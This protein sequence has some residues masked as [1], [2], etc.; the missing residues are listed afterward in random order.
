MLIE[1]IKDITEKGP[2]PAKA[3]WRIILGRL[4]IL[5][6]I[7][8]QLGYDGQK[9]DWL[10]VFEQLVAPSLFNA[11]PEVRLLAIEVIVLFYQLIGDSVRQAT[12]RIEGLR[13]NLF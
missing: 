9:W 13:Q 7:L 12:M 4:E 2:S 3:P 6:E 11:N 1:K 8:R 5:R 10:S